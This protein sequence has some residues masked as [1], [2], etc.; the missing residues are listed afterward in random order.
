M[1]GL[2]TDWLDWSGRTN[3]RRY[4]YLFLVSVLLVLAITPELALIKN[5]AFRTW[6]V[7]A[8]GAFNIVLTGYTVRRLH[9]M[10]R[11]GWWAVLTFVPI[12]GII[13]VFWLI[14]AKSSEKDYKASPRWLTKL[15]VLSVC[16]FAALYASRIFWAPYWIPSGSM[17]PTL[18]VG[19]FLISKRSSGLPDRGD[20]IVFYHP[21]NGQEFVKR[22]I[23]LPGETVQLVDSTLY[24]NDVAIRRSEIGTFTEISERQGK[25]GLLPR[26]SNSPV[27]S[28]DVC[29]KQRFIEH[30]PDGVSHS[31]LDINQ[32]VFYNS[33]RYTVPEN[34]VF[35]LGDNRDNSTDSRVPTSAGGVGM[36]PVEN[37]NGKLRF[38]V[39]SY[40]GTSALQVR[41]W[42]PDRYLMWIK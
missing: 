9:D 4:I 34:H 25:L 15:G 1:N 33:H 29:E 41:T 28:G 7:V 2:F 13:V 17:K 31:V 8:F 20:I 19:D 26:C 42:R 39:F 22:V 11:N 6:I 5:E 23:G 27:R 32:N 37:I 21:V 3:R 12:L 36:V 40:K 10:G 38:L 14:F 18:L 24:I 16:L 35:V 30:L